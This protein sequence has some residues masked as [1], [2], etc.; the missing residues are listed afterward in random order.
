MWS[1]LSNIPDCRLSIKTHITV[2]DFDEKTRQKET[3][4]TLKK[5]AIFAFK[6]IPG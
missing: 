3:L 6:G 1:F 5:L 4:K 2:R